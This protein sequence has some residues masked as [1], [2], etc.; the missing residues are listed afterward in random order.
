MNHGVRGQE[1]TRTLI[2]SRQSEIFRESGFST[3]T[4]PSTGKFI[5]LTCDTRVAN[6]W[7]N[8]PIDHEKH[9][10]FMKSFSKEQKD[11]VVF[12]K[13]SLTLRMNIGGVVKMKRI[14]SNGK[15]F[16]RADLLQQTRKQLS[17]HAEVALEQK[18]LPKSATLFAASL[19][20]AEFSK[21]IS[22]KSKRKYEGYGDL[23][24]V[25]LTHHE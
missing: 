15:C 18:K 17:K 12:N 25:V 5:D 14:K 2:D 7:K 4:R 8:M 10:T 11:A 24:N 13:G 21:S 3:M 9:K 19:Q 16:T 22:K 1:A 20:R 6:K 23:Y